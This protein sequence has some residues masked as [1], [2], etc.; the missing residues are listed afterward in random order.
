MNNNI[1]I[2]SEEKGLRLSTL[3]LP[4]NNEILIDEHGKESVMVRIPLLTYKAV[5]LGSSEDPLPAFVVNGHTVPY[6]Y[7]S[8]YLNFLED[9][10]PCSR[11]GVMPETSMTLERALEVCSKKGSG[12]HLMSNSEWAAI[13]LWCKANGYL[14]NGNTAN[15]YS[16]GASHL[17]GVKDQ[18]WVPVLNRYLQVTRP[19]SG[20]PEWYHDKTYAGI[21]DLVGNLPEFVSGIR[22]RDDKIQVIPQN[23]SAMGVDE[24][25]SSE[26]WCNIRTDGY[27]VNAASSGQFITI[28]TRSTGTGG[29]PSGGMF[30]EMSVSYSPVPMILK[31]LALIPDGS[32][33]A[34]ART[35]YGY[36]I[37]NDAILR[38]G[39]STEG[40]LSGIFSI[41]GM[42][43]SDPMMIEP[44]GFRCAYVPPELYE[45]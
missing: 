12:W 22:I 9:D 20:P 3:S 11:P 4:P 38:G 29:L 13:A 40:I 21:A 27:Y 5:G 32:S 42:D 44:M 2:L 28:D 26:E 33:E 35:S 16:S 39:N 25:E 17:T 8:K 36:N 1:K 45:D 41:H 23:N 24:S 30:G 7:I 19:G 37:R 43:L 6:I 10:I 34:Y 18:V 14:P 15:G 31:A